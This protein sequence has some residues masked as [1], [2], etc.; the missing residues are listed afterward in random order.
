VHEHGHDIA[1]TIQRSVIILR[2]T[3]TQP[4]PRQEHMLL[5]PAIAIHSFHGHKTI[6][7]YSIH[8]FVQSI[9]IASSR[10]RQKFPISQSSFFSLCK[11]ATIRWA[12]VCRCRNT[13]PEL[14]TH[15][16]RVVIS[17]DLKQSPSVFGVHELDSSSLAAQ[18]ND[19]VFVMAT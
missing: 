4:G 19:V 9:C 13:K 18:H 6:I 15:S 7:L 14:C 17:S 2:T 11:N 16:T 3:T 10:Q 1:Q 5:T 12:R 8:S